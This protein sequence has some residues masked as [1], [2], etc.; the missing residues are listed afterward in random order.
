MIEPLRLCPGYSEA[1]ISNSVSE[2]VMNNMHFW[3][4]YACTEI[5]HTNALAEYG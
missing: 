3:M 1:S 2:A 5:N 4:V